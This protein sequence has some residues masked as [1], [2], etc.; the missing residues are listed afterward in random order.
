MADPEITFRPIVRS[1]HELLVVDDDPASRYATARLLRSAG[2]LTREAATGSEALALT[3]AGVSAVVLD[4]HLPDIDGFEICRIL[5]SR[6]S[7]A[8]LP[9]LH[10]SAAYVKDE[11]K[12][13][14]LDSG[15]DAYLTHP[16]E[17]AVLVATV[18]A[19]VRARVAEDAMRHGEAKF[20]A[21][22]AQVPVGI[23]VIDAESRF[24]DANPAMLKLLG[25]SLAEL[26]G[27]TLSA[28]LPEE[29]VAQAS[30]FVQQ[31]RPGE[32]QIELPLR[33][34][35]GETITVGW[36]LCPQIQP[37]VSMLLAT[38]NSERARLEEQ[39]QQAL[40]RERQA[41]GDA[42]RLSTMKDELIAVL[43]HELRTPLTAVTGWTHVLKKRSSDPATVE[44]ALEAIE[45]NT[46]LQATLISDLLDMSQ[47]NVGKIRLDLE[48]VDALASAEAAVS[49]VRAQADANKN[50]ITVEQRGESPRI[51]A[52]A[53]RVMQILGN[54][55]GNAVKFSPRGAPIRVEVGGKDDGVLLVVADEGQ[56][57]APT[58]LPFLFDRFAQADAGSSRQRGGLGLGLSIVRHL[59]HAHGGKISAHSA[60]LGHG[61]RFEVWLPSNPVTTTGTGTASDLIAA[62]DS[63]ALLTGLDVLVVDD[64]PDVC[65]MLQIILG[66]RGAAVRTAH[67][68]ESALAQLDTRVPDVLVSD[69]GMPGRDGYAL[70]GEVRRRQN[71]TQHIPAIALT[72]FTRA[73]DQRQAEVAGFDLHCPKPI[74]PLQLVQQISR[75]A[76]GQP[77]LP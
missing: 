26:S 17:P 66:D 7:T 20:K 68:Y 13:R 73:Q 67:D 57:I 42:E 21:I 9:V 77:P 46:K 63:D 22:Y 75:L 19:L 32:L 11:D 51:R 24:L 8:R 5:R 52:D 74:Q 2:F 49:G 15:A 33:G 31:A 69:I 38:D 37:G 50:E 71:G 47:M 18:Q 27:R 6:E 76:R 16:V 25:R 23:G 28:F 4:V 72:S 41:R 30:A 70:I 61:A 36:T 59:V 55:L 3:D 65:A 58:F 39:R 34:P 45:R 10:L 53:G 44:R 60:G 54:L 64:D 29:A 62:G 12:V 14:G 35:A 43:S 1:Q 56:G 48:E 40:V